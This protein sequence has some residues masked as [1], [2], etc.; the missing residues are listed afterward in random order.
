M[1]SLATSAFVTG[2]GLTLGLIVAI[3][4]QDAF[5]LRQRH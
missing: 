2:F 4:A 1:E 3:G 5:V